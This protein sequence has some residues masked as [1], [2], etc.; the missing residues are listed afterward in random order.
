M[1]IRHPSE[2]SFHRCR[3]VG[4]FPRGEAAVARL[5]YG[6]GVPVLLDPCRGYCSTSGF[7]ERDLPDERLDIFLRA[8]VC[9][10]PAH[11]SDDG[12]VFVNSDSI[13]LS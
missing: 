12:H 13:S 9:K 11:I 7:S 5:G 8:T 10:P 4:P 1:S 2:M 3:L 6:T